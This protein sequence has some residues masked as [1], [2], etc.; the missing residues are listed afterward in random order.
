[1]RLYVIE[2][3]ARCA[4]TVSVIQRI[5]LIKRVQFVGAVIPFVDD[6]MRTDSKTRVNIIREIARGRKSCVHF[7]DVAR[8]TSDFGLCAVVFQQ[9]CSG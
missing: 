5:Q 1:M 6:A 3:A 8:A 4:H 9:V 7:I 2:Y